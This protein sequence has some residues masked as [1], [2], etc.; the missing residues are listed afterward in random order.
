MWCPWFCTKLELVLV[1]RRK[2]NSLFRSLTGISVWP[3]RLT[4][5]GG[6]A[7]RC[8][9]GWEG[10]V[11]IGSKGLAVGRVI[12]AEGKAS[13]EVVCEQS[14]EWVISFWKCPHPL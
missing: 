13:L 6:D 7:R 4:Q 2:R 8:S 10:A 5:V 12:P 11:V 3:C 9:L 1:A 14:L